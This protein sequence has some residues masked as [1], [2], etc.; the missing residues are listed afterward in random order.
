MLETSLKSGVGLIELNR[1]EKRNALSVELL[2]ALRHAVTDLGAGKS[3]CI[4]IVGRGTAFSAGADLDAVYSEGFRSELYG[5]LEAIRAVQVPVIAAVNGPA[6]GA[7]TQLALACDLRVGGPA[8]T[9]AVPTARNGLVVDPWTVRRLSLLAGG[10]AARELLLGG[11]LL[12][13][14]KAHVRG[15]VDRLGNLQDTL[16]WA[17]EIAKFAP[18]S[19]SY[20]KLAL[21]RLLEP[22]WEQSDLLGCSMPAGKVKT[23]TKAFLRGRRTGP[24]CSQESK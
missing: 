8:A 13:V 3:R 22:D 15:L 19:L 17:T 5:A 9:F 20:S 12:D 11:G 24:Q 2:S 6:I 1:P 23:S 21:E 7:G 4:V 16:D 14:G 18:M 10:G